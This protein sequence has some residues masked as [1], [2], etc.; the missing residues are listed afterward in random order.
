MKTRLVR[1]GNSRGVR[2]SMPPCLLG[3]RSRT[4]SGSRRGGS[5]RPGVPGQLQTLIVA[6]LTTGSHSYPFRV[7][8][9][10]AGRADHVVLDQ[11]RTVD[12]ERLIRRLGRLA[13]STL[14]RSLGVLQEMF[15]PYSGRLTT[16][17]PLRYTLPTLPP[18]GVRA[19]S[20]I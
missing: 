13:P 5:A 8:C 10:F 2:C 12:R 9:R 16:R 3:A 1:I 7:P 11:I 17:H 18:S 4:R 14:T 15:A 19:R 20:P 6:P